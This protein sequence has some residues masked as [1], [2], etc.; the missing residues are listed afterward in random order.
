M[1]DRDGLFS[2][3]VELQKDYLKALSFPQND[4]E[5]SFFQYKCQMELLGRVDKIWQNLLSI[6]LLFYYLLIIRCKAAGGDNNEYNNEA[7]FF[8]NGLPETIVPDSL[9]RSYKKIHNCNYTDKLALKEEDKKLIL[10][11][12]KHYPFSPYFTLKIAIK[13][14]AYRAQIEQ[15]KPSAI[16]VS[17][18]YSFTSSFL[19]YYLEKQRIKHINVMHGEKL[20]TMKDSFFRF[21]ECFVWDSH[22]IRLFEELQAETSQ[23]KI[24]VPKALIFEC[25]R[26]SCVYDIKY[27]LGGENIKELNRISTVLKTIHGQGWKIAVRPHPRYSDIEYIKKIFQDVDVED[28]SIKIENSILECKYVSARYSTVLLQAYFNGVSVMIDDYT[29]YPKYKQLVDLQYLILSKKHELL[30]KYIEGKNNEVESHV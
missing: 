19:T 7:V 18:E 26:K 30:S 13:I 12:I 17:G 11:I 14:A 21:S 22:Y 23:F 25:Q 16:I 3:P 1:R 15:I 4:L 24:E 8:S 5:R 6:P 10:K 29:D 20:Y 28:T 2:Y 9:F 27:Y